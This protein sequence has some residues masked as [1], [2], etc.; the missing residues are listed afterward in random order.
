MQNI[1]ILEFSLNLYEKGFIILA[2]GIMFR[3]IC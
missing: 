1:Y 3:T 2:G